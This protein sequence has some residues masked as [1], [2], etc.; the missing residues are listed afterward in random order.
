MGTP[1]PTYKKLP[2]ICESCKTKAKADEQNCTKCGAGLP[3]QKQEEIPPSWLLDYKSLGL[4][5]MAES[6]SWRY[7]TW[8]MFKAAPTDN[9]MK[10]IGDA[11]KKLSGVREAD[12]KDAETFSG[13]DKAGG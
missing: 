5:V 11:V 2:V 6:E 4:P 1:H 3:L 10:L 12:V 9:D 8:V 7:A 13:S